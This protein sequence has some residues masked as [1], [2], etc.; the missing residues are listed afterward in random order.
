MKLTKGQ[1]IF[2]LKEIQR[3]EIDIQK[4]AAWFYTELETNDFAIC[5]KAQKEGFCPYNSI[6]KPFELPPLTK[7]DI[8]Q[9]I[10]ISNLDLEVIEK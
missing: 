7:E 9:L 2:L 5:R 6:N 3:G 1:K 8:K 4:I 10:E